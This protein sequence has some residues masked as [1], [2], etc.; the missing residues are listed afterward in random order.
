[1]SRTGRA[2][3]AGGSAVALVGTFLPWLASGSVDRSSYDLIDLVE[4]LGFSPDGAVG[5][6]VRAWPVVPLLLVVSV[7]L[8]WPT[9]RVP[10]AVQLVWWTVTACYVGGTAIAVLVAPGASLFG[11]RSGVWVTLC[12][13]ASLA[14]GA[15]AIGLGALRSVRATRRGRAT[16]A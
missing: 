3:V 4:R 14:V 6:G 13:V 12:G 15:A 5:V 7:V 1:M 11:V 2:L 16:P 9:L 10:V 8:V